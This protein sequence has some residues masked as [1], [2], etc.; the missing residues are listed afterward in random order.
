VK[1]TSYEAPGPLDLPPV[2]S[3]HTSNR[4]LKKE[5]PGQPPHLYTSTP[6]YPFMAWCSVK[7]TQGQLYFYEHVRKPQIKQGHDVNIVINDLEIF[8]ISNIWEQKPPI[9]WIP[10]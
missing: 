2:T 7:K 6:Q 4:A 10:G 9:Q 3:K 5:T 1:C 8:I